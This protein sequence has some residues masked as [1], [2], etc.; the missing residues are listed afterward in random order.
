MK[1]SCLPVSLFMKISSGAM[2]LEDWIREAA[3]IGLDGFDLSIVMIKNHTPAYLAKLREAFDILPAV[4]ATTY[5]DFTHPDPAQRRREL[6]YCRADISLCSQLGIRYL[7]VLAGQ[8]HPPVSHSSGI[9]T[10]L[11]N[12][13]QA[14]A[15]AR[16]NGVTLLYEN[17]SKPSAW[18]YAD[19]SY[20]IDIFL[21]IL[22]GLNGSGIR[23]NFDIGNV[24]S[25]GLDP[26]EILP[27]RC[28]R[29]SAG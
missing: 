16:S 10:A 26:L 4:M 7:R 19:F 14:A 22:D 3:E 13:W 23:L 25:L 24:S 15:V 6:D 20:P 8:A 27:S 18:Q 5:P 12:L 29:F 21:E 17:H 11:D 9:S 28:M 1:I 2:S